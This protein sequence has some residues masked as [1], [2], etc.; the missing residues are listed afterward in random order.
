MFIRQHALACAVLWVLSAGVAGAV[1]TQPSQP[2]QQLPTDTTL[3]PSVKVSASLNQTRLEDMPRHTTVLT[4]ADIDKSPARTLDGLLR[5]VPGF[6]FTGLPAAMTDP[7]GQQTRMRGLGNAQVLVLM[8][9]VPIMDPFYLTTQFYKVPLANVE[10]VEV[11]RGGTSSLWGSM[12]V[13]GVVN[14]V[15]KRPHGNGGTLTLGAGNRG[16]AD[17][18]W[19]QNLAVSPDLALNL[20]V[21]RYRTDGY[22]LTPDE[23]RW[24]YPQ[25]RATTARN[26]NAELSAYFRLNDHLKGFARLGYHVQDQRISYRN[27]K[28]RQKNPDA[29][30]GLDAAFNDDRHLSLRAWTQTVHFTKYNG[31][32]C[33]V[34]ASGTCLSSNAKN[35]AVSDQVLT[36][37]T[38]HGEQRYRADGLRTVYSQFVNDVFNSFQIGLNYQRLMATDNE[39]FYATPAATTPAQVLSATGFGRGRQDMGGVFFQ[40]KVSPVGPL[41]LTLSGR[42]DMWRGSDQLH[43]LTAAST[44][45][46]TG[47]ALPASHKNAFNPSLGVHYDLSD[48]WS[49]RGAAYK[50]FRAP[51]F[52]NTTRSYG[53]APTTVANPAL[54]PEDTT[55]WEIGTDYRSDRLHVS[56]TYFADR[57]RHMIA[58]Y[59]IDP[60]LG[61]PAPVAL[62][63]STSTSDPNLDNCGGTAKYYTNDQ[64]GRSRG[65][66]LDA[67]WQLSPKLSLGGY[68]TWTHSFLTQKAAAVT[69]PLDVQLAG[70]PRTTGVLHA[71][72][73]PTPRFR[74][75]GQMRYIGPM[76]VDVTS[77][78]GTRY[79]QGG[80]VIFSASAGW[81]ATDAL[82]LKAGVTNL[83]DREYSEN[84]YAITQPWKRRWSAPRTVFVSATYTY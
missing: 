42:Y 73:K 54:R 15:T 82:A 65:V 51:G 57:I 31:A 60:A 7:T 69:T 38:Q 52:N 83:L 46:T 1:G 26:T 45:L 43:R 76:Y 55:G 18:A 79:R 40:A 32:T 28:N 3:L 35:D 16:T 74:L 71:T 78:P 4:R 9:G 41:Q 62:L 80:N 36:Y 2:V 24:R 67:R 77:T 5:T 12:A 30:I 37:Y 20:A 72:W 44:G 64:R 22:I 6:N 14:I 47:G 8:D 56:A 21:S 34:Q 27:G 75:Y 19:S 23:Y 29:A 25:L 10:R 13:A 48:R 49:V 66:E 53:Q 61:I 63:C 17:L 81:A 70:L 33:Y 11:M 58:T 68:V 84:T 59:R 50:A 39:G